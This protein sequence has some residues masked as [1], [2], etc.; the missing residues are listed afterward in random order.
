[1]PDSTT[2]CSE[3]DCNSHNMGRPMSINYVRLRTFIIKVRKLNLRHVACHW[4][5]NQEDICEAA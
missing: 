5:S 2:D 4:L 3:K 1:M